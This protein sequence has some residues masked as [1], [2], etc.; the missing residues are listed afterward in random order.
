[1]STVHTVDIQ[2]AHN[3]CKIHRIGFARTGTFHPYKTLYKQLIV[4]GDAP[5]PKPLPHAACVPH[6]PLGAVDLEGYD[7]RVSSRSL[8]DTD[9][10]ID[11][12]EEVQNCG[13]GHDKFGYYKYVVDAQIAL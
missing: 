1:M 4:I 5:T 7:F 3:P 2:D 11:I 10:W 12:T 8:A 9:D 13:F 6:C